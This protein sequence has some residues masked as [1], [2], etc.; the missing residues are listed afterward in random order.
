MKM[1]EKMLVVLAACILMAGCVSTTTSTGSS[2]SNEDKAD[3][4]EAAKLNYQLG[5]R[6]YRNGN[7]DLARDRLLYSIELNPK[8]AVAHYTLALTY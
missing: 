1:S 6:Y 3:P 8:N 7:F 2:R 4:A 5:A